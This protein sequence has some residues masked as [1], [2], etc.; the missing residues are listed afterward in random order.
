MLYGLFWKVNTYLNSLYFF[1]LLRVLIIKQ[2]EKNYCR[3]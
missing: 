3:R 1:N 2:N